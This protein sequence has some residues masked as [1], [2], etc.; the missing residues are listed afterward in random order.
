MSKWSVSA[1]GFLVLGFLCS[2][3]S[4]PPLF[5][6]TTPK[7]VVVVIV[8]GLPQAQLDKYYDQFIDGGFRL[9]REKGVWFTNARYGHSAT[10]TAVGHSNVMT[11][12]Y[13][14]EHGLI[15]N[16]WMDRKTGKQVYC[17]EDS[18]HF[19]L[20]EP[21]I[22]AAGTSPRNLE[23]G[24]LGDKLR[25]ATGF[26]S[27]VMSVSGKDRSSILTAGRLGTAYFFSPQTG[28]F[29]TSTYYMDQY[30][31][32]WTEFYSV[33]PQDQW[34]AREWQLLLPLPFYSRSALDNRPQHIDELS[35]GKA[36][37]HIAQLTLYRRANRGIDSAGAGN[38]VNRSSNSG[39]I[40]TP[41]FVCHMNLSRLVL[42]KDYNDYVVYL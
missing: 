38:S 26:E 23:V 20:G 41:A 29:I 2:G 37:W 9:L 15:G 4:N 12:T 10:F 5:S 13:A 11:G 31:D 8:D 25:L 36:A 18:N 6:L 30:P 24:T 27:R 42:L 17:V 35:L 40:N 28:R 1:A 19:Y 3:F 33:K 14:H 34:F 32:W 21:T 7:L 16:K 39:K 22:E